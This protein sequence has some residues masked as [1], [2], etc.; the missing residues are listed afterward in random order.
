MRVVSMSS[1]YALQRALPSAA[2]CSAG[3]LDK[4]ARAQLAGH[5]RGGAERGRWVAK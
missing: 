1:N 2:M 3:A 5:R 4:V